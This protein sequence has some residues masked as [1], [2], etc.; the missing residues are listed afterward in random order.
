[1]HNY[2]RSKIVVLIKE[3]SRTNLG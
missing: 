2:S 3:R 1:M